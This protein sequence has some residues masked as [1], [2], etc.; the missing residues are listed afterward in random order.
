[1]LGAIWYGP[2]FGKVWQKATGLSDEDVRSG[3]QGKMLGTV[4]IIAVIVSFGMAMF[5]FRSGTDPA[6]Q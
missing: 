6:T 4:F 3:N 5:Y 1:V 2:I